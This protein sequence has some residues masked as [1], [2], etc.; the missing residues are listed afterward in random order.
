M[1]PQY[2]PREVQVENS[3]NEVLFMQSHFSL[4][5]KYMGLRMISPSLFLILRALGKE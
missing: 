5:Y 2:L 4:K 3:A 1:K